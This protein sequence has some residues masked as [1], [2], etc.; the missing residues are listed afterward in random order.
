M[1]G[2]Y[3]RTARHGD[4]NIPAPTS[5]AGDTNPNVNGCRSGRRRTSLTASL[6]QQADALIVEYPTIIFVFGVR[7]ELW[8]CIFNCASIFG[9][10]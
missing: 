10:I 3:G 6:V 8:E 1:G 7:G 4:D 9:E 2:A 5:W